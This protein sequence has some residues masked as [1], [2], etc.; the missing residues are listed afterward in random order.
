[1]SSRFSA[2][3]PGILCV[4]CLL[5][6]PSIKADPLEEVL[7]KA[8]A[9]RLFDDAYWRVLLRYED[10]SHSQR[11]SLVRLPSFF[12]HPEGRVNPEAELRA[13]IHALYTDS[14][15]LGDQAFA[16]RFPA[17]AAWLR[18]R[19]PIQDKDLSPVACNALDTWMKG[20]NPQ[21]ATLIF[22]AD[23]LNNPSSMFGH[24]LLRIDAPDQTEETRLLA[25]AINYAAQTDNAN[26]LDFAWKGVTGGYPG[27][28]S[29][30]PYYQ[31]VKEYNDFENRDL[32]E[33][34]LNLKPE[35]VQR[36]M[37]H[38]WE[39][40]G[41]MF[42]YYF[43]SSNCSYQLLGLV[44]AARPGLAMRRDFPVYAAPTDTLRRVLAEQGMLK[45]V[46]YRPASGT[47]LEAHA[48]QNPAAVNQAAMRL[49]D[50][51]QASLDGLSSAEQ[52]R[53]VEMGYDWLYY[54]YLAHKADAAIAPVHLRQ[55]LIRRSTY[56][57][58][59]SRRAPERPA[60][61]PANS[62]LTSE[63]QAGGGY[64][65]DQGFLSLDYRPAYHDLLDPEGGYR[66]GAAIDFLRVQLRYLLREEQLAVQHFSLVHIDSLATRN[67]FL[68]PK[69][70]NLGLGFRQTAVDKQGGFSTTESH[71]VGYFEG[72]MGLSVK[73]S[74]HALCYGVL[75]AELEGGRAL[76][77]GWRVGA[78]PRLGCRLQGARSQWLGHVESLW[79]NDS[80]NFQTSVEGGYQWNLGRNDGLRVEARYRAEAGLDWHGLSVG[81]RRYF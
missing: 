29:I 67:D 49:A 2:L 1:M 22:A 71:G 59:D 62:H 77:N 51:P 16:C 18:Q 41:V 36:L 55:L 9:S 8:S 17:R 44:E 14:A 28:F 38:L 57:E 32:W 19:L 24:T 33:Y 52:A 42:P 79:F 5:S 60:V 13:N 37:Q 61:D 11:S 7:E 31:K 30:L 81:W 65:Q 35:E 54:R 26:S 75:Q 69:S 48:G 76:D 53:A 3:L 23:Y 66:Q 43:F 27:A 70:W 80:S 25:Y 74:A 56:A 39:L 34:Q 12:Q 73:P 20:V 50:H 4:L 15:G 10:L 47:L 72:G 58:P 63:W 21:S 40:K 78:G 68:K 46:I 6:S 64:E 45:Q